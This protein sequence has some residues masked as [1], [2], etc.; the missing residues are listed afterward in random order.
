M[1]ADAEPALV[2]PLKHKLARGEVALSMV[3]RSYRSVEIG[4][5]ARAV[6]MDALYVDLEHAQLTVDQT[7][8][9][10]IAARATGVT[11]LVRLP[12]GRLDLVGSVLDGGAMGVIVPHVTSATDVAA[13]VAATR[14]P[15]GGRRSFAGPPVQ[16]DY[17]R[18]PTE[19]M[20]KA[21]NAATFVA[22]MIESVEAVD[23]VDEIAAVDGLDLMLVGS[24][25]LLGDM[26]AVGD[27][28]DDR[29]EKA[30]ARVLAAGRRTATAVG[31]GG[32]SSRPDLVRRYIAD[33]ATFVSVGTALGFLLRGARSAVSDLELP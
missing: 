1:T 20:A 11:P 19:E 9:V 7:S 32:L 6:G 4:T 5:V 31:V 25:D 28:D 24:N 30:Y 10:C 15:P 21:M 14:F 2:N 17:A 8:Q 18:L 16:L 12:E 33:G 29:L 27:Y 13:A 3:V 23:N 22:V 26:G